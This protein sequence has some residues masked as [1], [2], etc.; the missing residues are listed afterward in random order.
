M[1]RSHPL[2]A[3]LAAALAAGLWATAQAADTPEPAPPAA[4]PAAAE[5]LAAARAH[6]AAQRWQAAITEL[7]KVN[8]SGDADWNNLMGYALRKQAKPDLEG[9]QRHY[10][11][12]LRINPA[13]L[14]ALEY[15]GELALMKNDLPTAEARLAALARLCS[16]PCEPLDDL[17]QAIA[18]FKATGKP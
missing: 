18:R 17:K 14:G 16:T 15:A 3:C 11:A 7:K 13:H 1:Y 10:D 8:A 4:R 12:A 9:A 2:R 6:L 5:P